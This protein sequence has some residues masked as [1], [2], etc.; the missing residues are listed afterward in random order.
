MSIKE[1]E[2]KLDGFFERLPI[3]AYRTNPDGHI[4][5]V[6]E[7]CLRMFGFKNIEEALKYNVRDFYANE[8]A[9]VY[10]QEQM[11]TQGK[12]EGLQISMYRKDGKIIEVSEYAAA[13]KDK[14]NNIT[15]YEGTLEDIT[16]LDLTRKRI[17]Y[18]LEFENLVASISS[19]FINLQ[20]SKVDK[21]IDTA[22]QR[23]GSFVGVD[24]S[25][26]F[27]FNEDQTRINN[28]HEWCEKG[29]SHQ[30]ENL[31]GIP[32]SELPW[33][34]KHLKRKKVINIPE[35]DDIP[36]KGSREKEILKSQNIQSL[37]VV[38]M[39]YE[40]KLRGFTGF[41]VVRNKRNFSDDTVTLLRFAGEIFINA[42]IRKEFEEQLESHKKRLEELV[43]ERTRELKASNE[44]L[45][46][47]VDERKQ[48][49]KALK[50]SKQNLQQ[51]IDGAPFPIFIIA[52]EE[53]TFEYQNPTARKKLGYE[54]HE[55]NTPEKWFSNI[56]P[57]P[58]ERKMHYDKFWLDLTK[59]RDK[60]EELEI[61]YDVRAKD[62][63]ILKMVFNIVKLPS[64][65]ILV[66]G[67]DR[68]RQ[69]R[70][71]QNLR[72]SEARFRSLVENVNEWIWESDTQGF[73]TYSS[74]QVTH[75]IGYHPNE[76]V[77]KHLT[78][79][80]ILGKEENTGERI[81]NYIEARVS[82]QGIQKICS[83]KNGKVVYLESSG[84]PVFN[85]NNEFI[86]FRGVDRDVSDKILVE[87]SIIQSEQKLS[88]HI[89][90][91][92]LG[93][94]EWDLNKEVLDWNQ[95]ARK[96]FGYSKSEA[97]YTKVF[98]TIFTAVS[99]KEMEK[100]WERIIN[101]EQGCSFSTEN[102]TKKGNL[103][104]CEWFN[105]PLKNTDG[106]IIGIASMV[107]DVTNKVK[108]EQEKD[109]LVSIVH[110]AEELVAILTPEQKIIEINDA[111]KSLLG[112][113]DG[114]LPDHIDF[115]R[116]QNEHSSTYFYNDILPSAELNGKW[117]GKTTLQNQK[118]NVFS[119]IVKIIAYYNQNKE[120]EYF[121]LIGWPEERYLNE[122][123][124][125]VQ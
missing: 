97:I 107:Q 39:V 79:I 35:V 87:K 124:Y 48:F 83:H 91:M 44:K 69:L 80:L 110:K 70:A 29:I 120:V 11:K 64:N 77:G 111:G 98:N 81:A 23:I 7:A 5:R 54:T 4:I 114:E 96:L 78:E 113:P 30:K 14:N 102:L 63:T 99:R 116:F 109:R 58:S 60:G 104:F 105:T 66:V 21:G 61:A 101:N 118:G 95:T 103:I 18:R 89:Q 88:S 43:E 65:K 71:E 123:G 42:I 46:Q 33:W 32:S 56:I 9:Y 16:P 13:I 85:Q 26:V 6:N 68:T 90:Q 50:E 121:S 40:N 38:P 82:F 67:Q 37:I 45:T 100:S 57:D 106:K 31:Q 74:P 55:I 41:D 52:A 12:V 8:E 122:L 17:Q 34:M 59:V 47:E 28:T 36:R 115:T 108:S 20:A 62:G 27:L 19:H 2:G 112:L 24:R 10:F 15:C 53:V 92:P 72:W 1:E 75:L 94:I 3:G 125:N 119:V 93:Y 49:E 84:V 117:A 22:L 76:I 51:V 73:I 25:Y 86:G